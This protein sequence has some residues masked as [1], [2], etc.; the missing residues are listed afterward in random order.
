M[1]LTF[2][3]KLGLRG[4]RGIIRERTVNVALDI[5]RLELLK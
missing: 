2:A 5:L 1:A 3:K 4:A